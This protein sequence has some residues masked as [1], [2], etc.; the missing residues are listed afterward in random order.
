MQFIICITAFFTF[1]SLGSTSEAIDYDKDIVIRNGLYFKKITDIPL[2][3]SVS[4]IKSGNLIDGKREGP[5]REYWDNGQLADKEFFKNGVRTGV[6]EGYWE[7]GQL[8]NLGVYQNGLRD[9]VWAFY[10]SDGTVWSKGTFKMGKRTGFW[11]EYF[12]NG[13]LWNKGSYKDGEREGLWVEYNDH[14]G[15]LKEESI[16]LA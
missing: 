13:K 7:N 6:W 14:G 16:L 4:G 3:G 1:F 9:G 2:T 12:K 8:W 5:W 15:Y 10:Y 11:V